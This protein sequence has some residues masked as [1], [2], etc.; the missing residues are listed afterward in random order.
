[1]TQETTRQNLS[2]AEDTARTYYETIMLALFEEAKQKRE[3]EA[4]GK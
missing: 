2:R 3:S 1:M 4:N